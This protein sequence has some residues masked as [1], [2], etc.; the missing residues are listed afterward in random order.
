MI[1][2][3]GIKAGKDVVGVDKKWPY[4]P[5]PPPPPQY[6]YTCTHCDGNKDAWGNLSNASCES[7]W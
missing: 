3:T 5:P 1:L 7:C 4:P 6:S 2:K